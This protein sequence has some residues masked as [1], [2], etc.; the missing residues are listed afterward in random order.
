MT[1][2]EI[3]PEDPMEEITPLNADCFNP[4]SRRVEGGCYRLPAAAAAVIEIE[5]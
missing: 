5:L 2:H 1:V 3:A 4:V